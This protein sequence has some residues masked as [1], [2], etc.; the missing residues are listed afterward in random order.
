MKKLI[1]LP[2]AVFVAVSF[3]AAAFA[4]PLTDAQARPL[5]QKL[6]R[7]GH[8][9]EDLWSSEA[10]FKKGVQP[11]LYDSNNVKYYPVDRA[12]FPYKTVR[13]FV[14]D[15]RRVFSKKAVDEM[16]IFKLAP[17]YKDV[18][19]VPCA[20]YL[21][22]DGDPYEMKWF[23]QTAEIVRQTPASVTARV[24]RVQ[25]R[26]GKESWALLKLDKEKGVWK[27]GQSS[28]ADGAEAVD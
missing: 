21:G 4:A 14:A 27:L 22:Q 17:R 11:E 25:T 18:G 2:L 26:N 6:V 3:A 15:T 8:K 23:T 24:K 1:L 5:I 19:G 7:E 20:I 13:S 12:K 28:Y 10:V 16:G 9:I